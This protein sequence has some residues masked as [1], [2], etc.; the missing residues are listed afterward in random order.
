MCAADEDEWFEDH[1]AHEHGVATLDVAVHASQLVL[2]FRSP[3]M[4]LLGFEHAPRS[5]Q[6]NAAVSRAL[7]WLRD[8]SAQFRP[9][10]DARCT[11][12]K[13]EVVP[14]QWERS[15]EHTEFA[16]NYEFSCERPPA[17][18]HLDVRLLEQLVPDVKLEV[19]VASPAGQHSAEL[20]RSNTRLALRTSGK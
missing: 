7:K 9:S 6:D 2:Q 8:P 1:H 15:A 17:L 5:T 10:A 14:P 19:Q 13:S 20:T 4:N 18:Q 16:A 11:V 12:T 3:A